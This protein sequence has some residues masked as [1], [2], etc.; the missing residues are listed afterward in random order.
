MSLVGITNLESLS[1]RRFSFSHTVIF[2]HPCY[3]LQWHVLASPPPLFR[4]A[5]AILH[6]QILGRL[7]F[8]SNY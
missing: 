8:S 6:I 3:S 1:S 2:N 5:K 4:L 7:I